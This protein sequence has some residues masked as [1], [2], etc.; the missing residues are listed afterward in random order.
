MAITK[1]FAHRNKQFEYLLFALFIGFVVGFLH[2]NLLPCI[3][4]PIRVDLLIY[5]KFVPSYL[6]NWNFRIL[7]K[8]KE[9]PTCLYI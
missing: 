2:F 5:S 7:S 8:K 3:R 4:E 6:G 9:N 1:P